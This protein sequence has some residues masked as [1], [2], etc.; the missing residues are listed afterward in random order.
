[1][2]VE[3]EALRLLSSASKLPSL[4]VFDLDYTLWPYYCECRSKRENPVLY[5]QAKGIIQ[6]FKSKGVSMAI[7]SRSPTADIARTFLSK[8][9]LISAFP[10][11][12]IYSS[13]S[14]KTDHFQKIHHKTGVPYKEMLFF[15]DEDRNI[16]AVTQMGVT[17]VYV[18]SGVNIAA[19]NRGLQMFAGIDYVGPEGQA[20]R[21]KRVTDF[22]NKGGKKKAKQDQYREGTASTD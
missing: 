19:L 17:S 22:F 1:M 7:A 10:V 15:D 20:F 11:M 2:N 6:A 8:L 14:H 16:Q 9:D 4:V 13:W 21:Q 12:E 3:S 5:P 18:T